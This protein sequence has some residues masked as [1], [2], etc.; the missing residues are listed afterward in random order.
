[1]NYLYFMRKPLALLAFL[2]ST[3]FLF[4]QS[5][6]YLHF[7]KV[8]DFVEVPNAS[9]YVAGS[10]GVS[11]TGWF[12]TDQLA[13]GQGMMG[14][15]GGG[16]G[17][18]EMYLIQLD[19][20]IIECRFINQAGTLFEF[21]APAFTIVPEEWQHVAWI[22]DGSKIELFIDGVSIGSKLASGTSPPPTRLS[23][24]GRAFLAASISCTA[25]AWTRSPSGIKP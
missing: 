17:N 25:A 3:G 8:D 12:Y 21:V 2:L 16:T 15:R 20:G 18:G 14:F 22:Y 6:Q 5:N 1:M 7:D 9:Q 4:S 19:N 23:G 11:M 24:S 10:S 13:Y